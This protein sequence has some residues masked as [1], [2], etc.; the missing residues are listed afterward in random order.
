MSTETLNAPMESADFDALEDILDELRS[1]D[2]DV[3]QWEFLEGAIA[4]LVCTRR[5]VPPSEYLPVLIGV[6]SDQSNHFADG[7]QAGRFMAL[8][9]RRWNEV[10]SALDTQVETLEDER[11]YHPEVLDVR[12]AIAM[13]P[14]AE[15]EAASAEPLPSFGQI[16]A[17]GFLSV[18][19]DWA[20][21]WAPPRDKEAAGWIEDALDCIAELAG[22][23]TGEPAFNMHAEDGPPS[24]SEARA[25]AYG[26]A[27]WAVYDLRQVWRSLGPR[28]EPLRKSA[29]P[30]RNDPCPCGSGKK[31]K[32]CHGA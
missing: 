3:P 19:E 6:G 26:E 15:R 5:V 22:D 11:T 4:A 7:A 8:W 14:E 32:K 12:G 29:E 27:I 21:D 17:L 13:L 23:D 20:D 10:A 1:R 28:T 25:N 16:W 18:V 24:V 30:G 2:E 31:Y 9:T